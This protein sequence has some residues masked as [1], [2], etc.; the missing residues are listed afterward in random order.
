MSAKSKIE[1]TDAT[2]NFVRGCDKIE[3]ACQFCYASDFAERWRGIKG[4]PYEQGFD[5]RLVPGKLNEPRKWKDPRKV[6]VNSMSD[7][8]HHEV[9]SQFIL[10]G[11]KVMADTPR[12]TYQILT[13]RHERMVE[14]ADQ[15]PWCSA[16]PNVWWGVSCGNVKYGF[17]RV[18]LLGES[19]IQNT[20]VSFE[21]LLEH[22]GEIPLKGIRWA[23][24]GGESGPKA[25]PC[26]I[27]WIR[28]GVRQCREAGIPAFVKQLGAFVVDR[29]DA[30]FEGD[31]DDG[32]PMD[33]HTQELDPTVYQ[34]APVRV[35][36]NHPKGGDPSE[37]PEDLRVRQTP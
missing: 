25:R 2:W 3:P 5:L 27:A 26:N 18:K 36:L 15:F 23:I 21:P 20:F 28:D 33:T 8:F 17:P 7:L 34:G 1:W 24:W 16:L 29:N 19:G 31:K 14:F 32:W 22:L 11:F 30:G 4:H 13:K 6:F 9:P 37:W 10:D 12:H 35:R